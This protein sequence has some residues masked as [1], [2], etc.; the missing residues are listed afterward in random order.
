VCRTGSDER[1]LVVS[2]KVPSLAAVATR[3]V[4]RLGPLCPRGLRAAADDPGEWDVSGIERW[5]WSET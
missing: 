4:L 3:T 1:Q 5:R 2:W